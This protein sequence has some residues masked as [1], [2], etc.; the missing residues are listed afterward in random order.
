MFRVG[1]EDMLL[2]ALLGLPNRYSSEL[3]QD[4][5][6]SNLPP[7]VVR[8]AENYIEAH[9]DDAIS[10][11]NLVRI[12]GCSQSVL[13][14]SFRKVRDYSPMQF[15]VEVRLQRARQRLLS[16]ADHSVS[17]VAYDAG[18]NHLGRFAKAYRKRFGETPSE[19]LKRHQ[20]AH[21]LSI[22]PIATL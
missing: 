8:L 11:S 7:R 19:T 12:C 6:R 5:R 16:G 10:V 9:A 2:A 4:D 3:E 18:F 1:I 22:P 14:Q 21:T 15:V 13:F 17:S 20:I